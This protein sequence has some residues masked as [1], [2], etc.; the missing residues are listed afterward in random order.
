M[1]Y[2]IAERFRFYPACYSATAYSAIA[3]TSEPISERVI[4]I[5]INTLLS[6]NVYSLSRARARVCST[7]GVDVY[8]LSTN[9]YR[10]LQ[11]YTKSHPATRRRKY[12]GGIR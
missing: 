6:I 7:P 5:G 12:K 3:S 10:F 8:K 4:G 2:S 11:T 1:T 9:V